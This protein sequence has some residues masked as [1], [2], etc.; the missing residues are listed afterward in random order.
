MTYLITGGGGFIGSHLADA[1][2]ARGHEI[3]I[4]DDFSTGQHENIEHLVSSGAAQV[5]DGSVTDR[6][7]VEDAMA[8]CDF[9]LHLASAVGVKLIVSNALETMRRNVLGSDA[10]ISA[11]SRHRK[12]LL[13]VSTSEVYGKNSGDALNE[14][15]DRV[16]GSPLKSR[17]SYAIAKSYGEALAQSYYRERG[18]D[19]TIVRLFNTIGPRQS[20]AYGMVVPRLVRQALAGE[21]V[22]VYGDGTQSRCFLH[23]DDAVAAMLR[24]CAKNG[25]RGRAFNIGNSSPITIH[26]LAE[27]IIIRAQSDSAI[28][29]VPYDE[30]YDEG[31]EELGR[32]VP[33]TSA[34][35]ELTGWSPQRTLDQA[36]DDVIAYQRLELAIEASGARQDVVVLP[37]A[38]APAAG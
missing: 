28:A 8:S 14:D 18:A 27:R 6:A 21:D 13:F 15:S 16:L 7:L 26:A 2:V 19:N 35:H 4:L 31:F 33:D 20:G 38:A 17:W 10:V 29:F 1:L 3:M 23:V 9:C 36:L 37:E 34:V 32:R 5:L 30:A 24:V 11:A 12:A 22:T 25:A